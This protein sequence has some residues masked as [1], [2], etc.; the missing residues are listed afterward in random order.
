[1]GVR[2]VSEN[3]SPDESAESDYVRV[4]TFAAP[5]NDTITLA[6]IERFVD[7]TNG[8]GAWRVKTI[9]QERPMTVDHALSLATRYAERKHIPVVYAEKD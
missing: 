6:T 4:R 1:M 8:T 9:V 5:D 7:K 3:T 2:I